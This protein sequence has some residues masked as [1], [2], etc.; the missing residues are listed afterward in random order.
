MSWRK[1]IKYQFIEQWNRG[2]RTHCESIE[3][4]IVC[5][6]LSLAR[7][8]RRG[9]L[10]ESLQGMKPAGVPMDSFWCY[11]NWEVINPSWVTWAR[12]C[13]W[14]WNRRNDDASHYV[15]KICLYKWNEFGA[16]FISA[17]GTLLLGWVKSFAIFSY[18]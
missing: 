15:D 1:L 5:K 14:Y 17:K 12:G 16:E 11:A 8:G 3:V 10:L 13:V 7:I 4:G 6:F 9:L 18:M 2:W